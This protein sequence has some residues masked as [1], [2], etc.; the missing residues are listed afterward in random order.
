MWFLRDASGEKVSE[1]FPS[2][3]K[4]AVHMQMTPQTLQRA[5]RKGKNVFQFRGQEVK[6]VQQTI[7][8]FAFF[9]FPPS[10]NPIETFE[11]VSEVAKWLKV[12]NQTVYAAAKRGDETKVKNKEGAVF[13]LKKLEV[14]LPPVSSPVPAPQKVVPPVPAP[15]KLSPQKVVP[16]VPAP[17]KLSLPPVPAPRKKLSQEVVPVTPQVPAWLQN[18][19]QLL[20]N[21]PQVLQLMQV[22]QQN[23]DTSSSPPDLGVNFL[24]PLLQ[25]QGQ[26]TSPSCLVQNLVVPPFQQEISVTPPIPWAVADVLKEGNRHPFNPR[27]KLEMMTFLSEKTLAEFIRSGLQGKM[28]VQGAKTKKI[29]LWNEKLIYVPDLIKQILVFYIR[30]QILTN[31]KVSEW[32]KEKV[33]EYV[34]S[35]ELYNPKNWIKSRLL[36]DTHSLNEKFVYNVTNEFIKLI[37]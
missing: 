30:S 36:A 22:L 32:F 14:T 18:F 37:F 21:L 34:Y 5:I 28:F 12:P 6:V 26:G 11:W 24:L 3:A 23:Q 13:W 31:E 27:K 20:Q 9:D 15:R 16:P 1:F 7:P 33:K 17:R 2:Q 10:G 4:L 19:P 35:D 25:Q 29:M 8:H